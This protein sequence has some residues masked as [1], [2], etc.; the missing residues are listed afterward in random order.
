MRAAL[1]SSDAIAFIKVGRHLERIRA[2]IEEAGVH[3]GA[4]YLERI[5]LPEERILPL[6]DAPAEAPYFSIVLVYKGAE[7]WIVRLGMAAAQ[8][9]IR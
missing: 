4:G 3:G 9:N 1:A 5:G 7:D 6:R 2:L 8:E